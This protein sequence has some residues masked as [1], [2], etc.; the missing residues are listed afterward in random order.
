MDN[1]LFRRIE[2]SGGLLQCSA[3]ELAAFCNMALGFR[4]MQ[5]SRFSLNALLMK[6]QNKD[7]CCRTGTNFSRYV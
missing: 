1:L 4:N 3:R 5:R 6:D 7:N 2:L